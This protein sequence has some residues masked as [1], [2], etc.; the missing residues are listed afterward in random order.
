MM[1]V[2]SAETPENLDEALRSVWDDQ[3]LKPQEIILIKDGTLDPRLDRVIDRWKGRLGDR[4]VLLSNDCNKG[5]TVSLNRGIDVA[6]SEYIARMDTDDVALPNR[7]AIQSAFLDSHPDVV[8]VGGYL[9]EFNRS[10]D[11]LLIRRYPLSP[12]DVRDY[13]HKATPVAH[14]A[15]MMRADLFRS[16]LRYDER[17]RTSQ[18]I[19]LWFDLL[20]KG[21][22]ISNVPE[23]ILKFR[24]ED[25]MFWR[26][27]KKKAFNEFRIY[28]NGIRRMRGIWTPAYVYPVLRFIFRLMPTWLIGY[29][30]NSFIRTVV[31]AVRSKGK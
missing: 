12:E 9:Q 25:K 8:V 22:K 26:R 16:G 20:L 1:S 3:V 5:L 7:F 21:Y 18:D 24:R 4:L 27:G 23:V 30:Y 15:V 28:M 29:V 13:I 11:C 19:A 31:L 6:G 10:N 2:Y 14:P 17:Y